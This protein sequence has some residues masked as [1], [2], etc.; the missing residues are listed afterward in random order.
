VRPR[1]IHLLRKYTAKWLELCST[2]DGAPRIEVDER[3]AQG[4]SG[5]LWPAAA[6]I[7]RQFPRRQGFCLDNFPADGK[8][9]AVQPRYLVPAIQ[10]LC[11]E[12]HK[13]ALVSG[14]RQCGKTTLAQT[15]LRE[16]GAGAY[17]NWDDLELRRA[18]ARSPSQPWPPEHPRAVP[19]L[20][21]DEIHKARGW[22]RTVKGLFDTRPFPLDMLV[23]G[24]ARLNVYKKGGDSLLGRA[25][26]FRMHPF[27]QAELERS[28]QLPAD[29]DA[30]LAALRVG[31]L[32]TDAAATERFRALL[33]FGGFPEPLLAASDRRARA[34][35]RSRIEQVIR[36]DLRDLSALPDVSRVE[37]LAAL[38]PDRVGSLLSRNSLREDLEVGYDTVTRWLAALVE[39]YYAFE[40][41]PYSVRVV[42]SLKKEG[43]IYMWDWSEVDAPGP[44]FENLVACHLLKACDYWT[45]AGEGT[46]ELRLL[47]NRE[48]EEI[49]FLVVRDRK[50]WL[51]VEAKLSDEAPAPHWRKFLR[52]LNA[53]LGLQL[54][55]AT[56]VWREHHI[57]GH[58][59]VI[60]SADQALRYLV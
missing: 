33:R 8:A 16:R 34:W 45:D 29:P 21:L 50:P 48:K 38:L 54:V 11:F 15:L 41:K 22:K 12:L 24:S 52:Y 7:I 2:D 25:F 44:R 10:E 26:H 46:F 32:G 18:W 23:T 5:K 9:V 36:E 55:A 1:N 40:V 20:V 14:P 57:D 35:R 56:G 47:R 27:S 49:D 31:A 17:H 37:M 51:A 59:I 4:L 43:K 58:R 13:I 28:T 60:A 30:R 42:R 3:G 53:P 19:L 39:L 6:V